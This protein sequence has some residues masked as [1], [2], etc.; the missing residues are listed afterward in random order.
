MSPVVLEELLESLSVPEKR[1]APPPLSFREIGYGYSTG[2]SLGYSVLLHQLVLLLVVLW[3]HFAFV[4]TVEARPRRL[5]TTKC[6]TFPRWVVE[7]KARARPAADQAASQNFRRECE[8]EAGAA[9]PIPDPSR[10][11]PILPGL[12]LAFKPFFNLL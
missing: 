2:R 12:C 6:S 5:D 3:G 8:R 4:R 9:L 7:A 10:W 11:F 1:H